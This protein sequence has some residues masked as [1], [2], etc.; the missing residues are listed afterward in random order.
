MFMSRR[1]I[2]LVIAVACFLLSAVGIGFSGL[3]LTAI[4]LVAFAGASS[5]ERPASSS[6]ERRGEVAPRR[7]CARLLAGSARELSPNISLVI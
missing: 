5:S 7:E 1:S 6:A 4:G 3:S 2:L